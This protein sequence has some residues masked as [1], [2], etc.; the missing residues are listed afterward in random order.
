MRV[1]HAREYIA[2]FGN[3][4]LRI[5]SILRRTACL[6]LGIWFL[7]VGFLSSD[8]LAES[9]TEYKVKAAFLYHFVQFAEW[10]DQAFSQKDTRMH[11]CNYGENA[12]EGL[13]EKTFDGKSVNTHRFLVHAHVS[14]AEMRD[15]HVLFVNRNVDVKHKD[16]QRLLKQTQALLVG[17]TKDFLEYGGMIQ[18]Y[19]VDKK[20]RFAVN[21]DALDR[22]NIHL[23]SKL[24]RLAKIVRSE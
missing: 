6:F 24:L 11:I 7:N 5:F 16:V 9:R 12:F 23:S 21:P 19:H 4:E 3:I 1:H 22:N 14:T 20:I 17:E 13:L 15:C 2:E 18:F 10:P 8:S